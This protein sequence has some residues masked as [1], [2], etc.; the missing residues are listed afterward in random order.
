MIPVF[1][2]E[3][4][5]RGVGVVPGGVGRRCLIMSKCIPVL[6]FGRGGGGIKVLPV[7]SGFLGVGFK[8]PVEES[9]AEVMELVAV[10]MFGSEDDSF[11]GGGTGGSVDEGFDLDDGSCS[12]FS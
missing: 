11:G 8:G 9:V 12:G 2:P 6:V 4:A 7:S 1:T 3:K 5:V 10:R